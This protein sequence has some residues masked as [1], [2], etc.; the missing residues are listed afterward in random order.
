LQHEGGKRVA[1]NGLV[2]IAFLFLYKIKGR[3]VL[4]MAKHNYSVKKIISHD[5]VTMASL[6]GFVIMAGFLAE[7]YFAGY[8]FSK[9]GLSFVFVPPDERFLH[10]CIL[11]GL[12][13]IAAVCFILRMNAIKSYFEAG[14]K[15]NG[16]IMEL[17]YW[18]DRGTIIY[19]YAVN[20]QEYCG[21]MAIHI[22]R[23][24]SNL[25]KGDKITVL[26]KPENHSKAI[27]MDI[28]AVMQ[29]NMFISEYGYS[30]TLPENWSEYELDEDEAGTNGFFNA[31]EWS[32]NLRITSMNV[33]NI[34]VEDREQLISKELSEKGSRKISWGDIFGVF[35][36]KDSEHAD[37]IYIYYWYLIEQKELYVCSFTIDLQNKDSENTRKELGVVE[38]ILKSLKSNS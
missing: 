32:G 25:G 1:R 6:I 29:A 19:K 30:I 5:Y 35:F 27:I 28:F 26:V 10:Y 7:M 18:R 8:F 31:Q 24:T 3:R 14:I 13:L 9:R 2:T 21:K 23:E 20:G 12:A 15:A 4:E 37:D 33:K 11:G 17:R 34:D 38:E 22:T 16:L 36:A